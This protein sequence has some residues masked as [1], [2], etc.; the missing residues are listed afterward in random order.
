MHIPVSANVIPVGN[1][2][3]KKLVPL[4]VDKYNIMHSSRP[5]TWSY[6]EGLRDDTINYLIPYS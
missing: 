1:Y 3:S 2:L 6:G 5:I 4:V